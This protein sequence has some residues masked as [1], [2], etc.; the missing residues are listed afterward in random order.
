LGILTCLLATL[1]LLPAVLAW[2][3]EKRPEHRA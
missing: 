2:V 3:E 1:I